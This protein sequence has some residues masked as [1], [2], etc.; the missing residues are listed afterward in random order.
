MIADLFLTR[1][2]LEDRLVVPQTSILRD[3]NGFSVYIVDRSGG[4]PAARRVAVETGPTFGGDTV[5]TEGL[6]SGDEVIVT[7]QN[8]VTDGDGLEIISTE[9]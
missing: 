7:G 8:S 4:A 9:S 6:T 1:R 3:E 2:V 5:V